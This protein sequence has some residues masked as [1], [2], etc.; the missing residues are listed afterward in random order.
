LESEHAKWLASIGKHKLRGIN[1]Y[2]EGNWNSKLR[3]YFNIAGIPHYA[4]INR[5][6]IL[7]ENATD[8]APDVKQKI[9]ALL[10]KDL[11]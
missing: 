10:D 5:Q 7:A 11:E 2:A 6:N 8:K 4:I 1:L 9:D 3:A